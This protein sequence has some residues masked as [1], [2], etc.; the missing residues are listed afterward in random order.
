MRV[1]TVHEQVVLPEEIGCGDCVTQQD[2]DGVRNLISERAWQEDQ[3]CNK[4][5]FAC[6]VMRHDGDT[7]CETW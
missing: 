5:T 6:S 3:T 7:P 1:C 2:P 4:G